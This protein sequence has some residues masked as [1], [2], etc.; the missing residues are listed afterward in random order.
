MTKGVYYRVE[1]VRFGRRRWAARVSRHRANP[2]PWDVG[3]TFGHPF[4][5]APRGFKFVAWT[6]WGLG[7]QIDRAIAGDRRFW[8]EPTTLTE[9]FTVDG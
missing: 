1:I 7:R 5:I 9:Q 3:P 6:R 2:I 8:Y 4:L